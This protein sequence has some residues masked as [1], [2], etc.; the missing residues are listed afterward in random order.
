MNAVTETLHDVAAQARDF[1]ALCRTLQLATATADGVPTASYA[2]FALSARGGFYI[3]VSE[4]AEHT[5]NLLAGRLASVMFIEPE[6]EGHQLFARRRLTCAC[7]VV[8][9]ARGGATF[10]AALAALRQRFG[11]LVDHLAGFKDFH[12]FE[13]LPRDA[14]YVRGFGQA[15]V[16]PS[17][18]FAEARHRNDRGHVDA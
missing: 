7:D 3:Y 10:D 1:R 14:S 17:G 18:D 4:L 2:P 16:I 15:F 6:H 13:L 8:H 9:L 11:A 5:P 12:A